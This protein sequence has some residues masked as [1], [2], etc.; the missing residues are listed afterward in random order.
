M[1]EKE[2]ITNNPGILEYPIHQHAHNIGLE[3]A[4]NFGIPLALIMSFF[5]INILK[6]S[7]LIIYKNSK[8]TS[9]FLINKAWFFSVIII[10]VSHMND[11]TYYDGKVSILI[12]TL[13]AGL[14]CIVEEKDA[15]KGTK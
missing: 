9:D 10:I 7:Y 13:L 15:I 12:W 5:I 14:K 2:W 3:L 11:V 1:Y 4:Y 6:N 8:K